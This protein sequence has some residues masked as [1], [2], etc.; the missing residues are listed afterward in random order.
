MTGRSGSWLIAALLALG[1]GVG[2]CGDDDEEEKSPVGTTGAQ[3]APEASGGGITKE[4]WD[5]VSLKTPK[6]T[7]EA[8]LGP[9]S[10]RPAPSPNCV[11]YDEKGAAP[12]EGQLFGFC[13]DQSDQVK[14]K[15]AAPTGPAN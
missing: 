15:T 4:Q 14:S 9:P 7:V 6:S 11:F 8:D 2:G 10:D 12:G 5:G 3:T 13:Y 1:I